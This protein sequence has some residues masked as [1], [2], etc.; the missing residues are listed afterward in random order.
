LQR[1][2]GGGARLKVV[3]FRLKAVRFRLKVVRF[4]LKVVRFRPKVVRF[5]LKV[6]RFR[7]KVVRFRLKVVRFAQFGVLFVCKLGHGFGGRLSIRSPREL[8][9]GPTGTVIATTTT[10]TVRMTTAIPTRPAPSLP[11]T[12]STVRCRCRTV[13]VCAPILCVKPSPVAFTSSKVGVPR[14]F[15]IPFACLD[16]VAEENATCAIPV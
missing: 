4:R 16:V 9:S 2:V 5:R 1:S 15:S 3:R 7:L 11:S 8:C 13:R 10:A 6:V 12:F 14:S